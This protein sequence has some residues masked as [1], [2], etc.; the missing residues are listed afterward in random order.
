MGH[1]LPTAHQVYTKFCFPLECSATPVYVSRSVLIEMNC[2]TL[3]QWLKISLNGQSFTY[4]CTWGRVCV[5]WKP[6][7]ALRRKIKH[8]QAPLHTLSSTGVKGIMEIEKERSIE[9]I[10]HPSHHCEETLSTTDR[11]MPNPCLW[12]GILK[13][14]FQ[15]RRWFCLSFFF[16]EK[17]SWAWRSLSDSQGSNKL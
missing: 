10:V 8:L 13:F 15:S 14:K 9:D 17:V 1:R 2:A 16:I 12:P 11:K 3:A 5:P 4:S 6:G 7:S